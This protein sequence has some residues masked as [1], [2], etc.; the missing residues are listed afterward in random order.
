[1]R[2]V[3]ATV[4]PVTA[5]LSAAAMAGMTAPVYAQSTPSAPPVLTPQDPPHPPLPA[6]RGTTR[7]ELTQ[8][9]QNEPRQNR[10][11]VSDKDAFAAAPCPLTGSAVHVSI[12]AV[13]FKG[14]GNSPLPAPVARALSGFGPGIVGDQP[15]ENVC[16]IRDQANAVLHRAGYIA[17]VQIP[18]QDL[19]SGTLQLT[20][21]T[22]HLREI[23]V[24]GDAGPYR[25]IMDARI[26][27]L[28]ALNP[29]NQF[30]AERILLEARDIPGLDVNLSLRSAGTTPGE[31]IGDLTVATRPYDVLVNVQ[32][33]GSRAV[34]PETGFVRAT[35]YG[36]TGHADA[37]Y[38][39]FSNTLDPKEQSVVQVGH[40]MALGAHGATIGASLIYAVSRPTVAGLDLRTDSSIFNLEYT[41]PLLRTVGHQ[42]SFAGGLDMIE[43]RSRVYSNGKPQPLNLDKIRV[44]YTDLDGGLQRPDSNGGAGFLVRGSIQ[45]RQGLEIFDATRPGGKANSRNYTATQVFGDPKAFVVRSNADAIVGLGSTFSLAVKMQSQWSSHP[46]LSYEEYSVGNLSI[47]RGYDPG[48]NSA[49]SAMAL[50]AEFRAHVHSKTD[51]VQGELFAFYDAVHL[52]NSDPNSTERKRTLDSWGGGF[53]YTLPQHL[54]AEVM[55]AQP[56]DRA[57][58]ID[59]KRPAGRVMFSLTTQFGPGAN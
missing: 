9:P 48:A 1:M 33:Y 54:V 19:S 43:Q 44:L 59:R 3:F 13:A 7:Q 11:H 45:L 17:A 38:I 6:R 37:T 42:L 36:L 26:Q 31:V 8:P 46:L 28:M 47:G 21:V 29:L 35:F 53:R 22:A 50:R 30:D 24:H 16:H 41:H 12:T 23:R 39:G 40:V 56:L 55:Y 5:L 4:L 32:N 15:V 49:D 18:A 14:T 57:L 2:R 20:V 34:G 58:S 27:Q 10:A 51:N 25:K 52:W